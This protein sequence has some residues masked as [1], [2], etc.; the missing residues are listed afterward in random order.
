M[1][2]QIYL[3]EYNKD[4]KRITLDIYQEGKWQRDLVRDG[5]NVKEFKKL[6]RQKYGEDVEIIN[7]I[8]KNR[9]MD[10]HPAQKSD[11]LSLKDIHDLMRQD[12]A[13]KSG[14]PKM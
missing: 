7:E 14:L 12:N 1:K 4:K 5:M 6:I 2:P 13:K 9:D 3:K 10:V 11:G 8:S